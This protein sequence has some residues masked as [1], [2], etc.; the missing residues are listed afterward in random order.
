MKLLE[1]PAEI[2]DR[3]DAQE[4]QTVKGTVEFKDV[5]FSYDG[6]IDALKNVNFTMCALQ[7]NIYKSAQSSSDSC[8][9][10]PLEQ[11]PRSL[12]LVAL[13]RFVRD[14]SDIRN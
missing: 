4:L 1:E 5:C 2:V 10:V 7:Y 8:C 3:P 9:T 11:A 6:K 12:V 13:A 14:C